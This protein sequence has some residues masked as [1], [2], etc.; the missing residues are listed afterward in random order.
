[1]KILPG[2]RRGELL[3]LLA[4]RYGSLAVGRGVL[5]IL[6]EELARGGRA[7]AF[8]LMVIDGGYTTREARA[9]LALLTGVPR[10]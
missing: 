1:M 7:R 9:V 10:G 5:S 2:G 6:T 4:A 3:D 8:D